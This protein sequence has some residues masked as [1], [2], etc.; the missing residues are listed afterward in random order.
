MRIDIS[1]L[2]ALAATFMLVFARVGAMVM[3]LPGLGESNIPVRIKIAIALLL[4]LIIVPLHRADYHVNMDTLSALLVMFIYEILIGI[5]LGATARVTLAA[6]QV[7]GA[8]IAQQLGLGFVTSVDPTQGQQGVVI[9]NFLTLL[10]ITMLFATDSH[11]LVIAALN[12]SYSIFSPGEVMPSGDVAALATRAFAAAFKIGMQLSA[13]F[14]VFGLVFNV[15]LGVLARLMPQMQVYFVGVPLSI[16]AG[17]LIFGVVL[18]AM[19]GSF[20][21]Y[22]IAVMHDMIPL[23]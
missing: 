6:L 12:D 5:V 14:L 18:T 2:P 20:L 22:F 7:A 4:T 8:V 9:G 16:L 11:H 17:F 19:M 15:G 3:L 21:D 10:G 23:K 1:L 13:P